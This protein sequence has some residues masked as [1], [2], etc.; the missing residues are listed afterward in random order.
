MRRALGIVLLWVLAAPSCNITGWMDSPS[1]NAQLLSAARAC[2]DVG[3]LECAT[4]YYQQLTS[5]YADISASEQ[6]FAIL[7]NAGMTA[8]DF[9]TVIVG[10]GEPDM[11]KMLTKMASLFSTKTPGETKRKALF[12]AYQL[13]LTITEPSLKSVVK[14]ITSMALAAELLAEEAGGDDLTVSDLTTNASTCTSSTE[15]CPSACGKPGA[16]LV[17]T[18]STI[19]LDANGATVEGT[20]SLQM[21]Q[22]AISAIGSGASTLTGGSSGDSTVTGSSSEFADAF[23]AA[24]AS[25]SDGACYRKELVKQGIGS[26]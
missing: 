2:L 24:V 13:H 21:L 26:S 14:L 12:K 18:G 7:V 1:G 6:A 23:A 16:V 22:A 11:G 5:D 10:S 25:Q 20:P 8:G 15:D 19:D 17:A 4:T 9:L 3:D